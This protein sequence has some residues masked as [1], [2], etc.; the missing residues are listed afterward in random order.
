MK[1]KSQAKYVRTSPRKVRLVID[2]IR[3]KKAEDAMAILKFVNKAAAKPVLKVVK[4]AVADAEHNF[5]LRKK[6]LVITEAKADEGPTLKRI[7]PRAKGS[8]F[9]IKKR[10]SHITVCVEAE[11]SKAKG[12]LSKARLSSKVIKKAAVG[13]KEQNGSES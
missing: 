8:A 5:N 7:R 13:K 4:S 10:T 12:E 1:V 11:T 6:D 3:G 2:L 9:E